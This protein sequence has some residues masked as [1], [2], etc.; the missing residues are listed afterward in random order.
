MLLIDTTLSEKAGVVKLISA[1]VA[2]VHLGS[3]GPSV[4][5]REAFALAEDLRVD[6]LAPATLSEIVPMKTIGKPL[7]SLRVFTNED[8][9]RDRA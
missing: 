2:D 3:E 1:A 7:L 8:G 9:E 5:S 6:L 4:F